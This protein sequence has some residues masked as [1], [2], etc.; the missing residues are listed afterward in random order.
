M[1]GGI[2]EGR[3]IVHA[4][5]DRQGFPVVRGADGLW[6]TPDDGVA[7][8]PAGWV[9][10]TEII[11]VDG[12]TV[13]ERI[14]SLPIGRSIGVPALQRRDRVERLLA[15]PAGHRVTV[16]FRLPGETAIRSAATAAGFSNSPWSWP[17]ISSP[18]RT[19]CR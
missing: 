17:R 15:F 13:G 12:M 11:G 9:P 14:A 10:G 19:R 3:F 1:T 7:R 8:P 16:D 4:P 6:F 2:V 5:D 18:R